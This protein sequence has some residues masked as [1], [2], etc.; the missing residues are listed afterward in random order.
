MDQPQAIELSVVVLCY[1]AEGHIVDFVANMTKIVEQLTPNFELV[2]VANFMEGSGDTTPEYI[3]DLAKEDIR[4]QPVIK[5]KKGMMGWDMR[6]GMKASKGQ[7]ICVID[8]DGQF[9]PESIKA[10]F[11]MIREKQL[12]LVKTYRE[13]RH[14]SFYRKLISVVY[15]FVFTLMFPGLNSKDA[16]SKPK[17]LSRSAYERMNLKSNDWFIDAEIMIFV[18][19]LKMSFEEYPII[20]Y[21][22]ND[23]GSFVKFASILEFIRNLIVYRIREFFI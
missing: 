18:R 21:D 19:R 5:P 12:D 3:R 10:G 6:E 2:L 9:P 16:N 20:F 15:N 11:E 4:I 23:R 14:D 17:F 7:Y 8:G 22:I 13:A 1:R